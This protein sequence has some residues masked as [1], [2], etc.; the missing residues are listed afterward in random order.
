M[1]RFQGFV[2]RWVGQS[3]AGRALELLDRAVAHESPARERHTVGDSGLLTR[4]GCN[5]LCILTKGRKLVV[6]LF[7]MN[8]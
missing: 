6:D 1:L 8:P 2:A 5:S 7:R 4:V 3:R